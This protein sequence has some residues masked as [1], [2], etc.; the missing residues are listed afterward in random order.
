MWAGTMWRKTESR[1]RSEAEGDGDTAGW[2]SAK[3]GPECLHFLLRPDA[4]RAP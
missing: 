3:P 1:G 4:C 2:T